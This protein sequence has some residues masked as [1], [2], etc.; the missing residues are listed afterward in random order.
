MRLLRAADRIS[1]QAGYP[2]RV[3]LRRLYAACRNRFDRAT[4]VA[5]G[6]TYRYFFHHYNKTWRSE[7]AIEIPLAR[8]FIRQNRGATR[9]LEV[10]NVL[11]HYYPDFQHDVVD[12]YEIA[13]GVMN[14][15]AA[16]FKPPQ[17]YGLVVSIST[18]E[19]VGWDEEPRDP[20]KAAR[21]YLN[22]VEN[23]LAPGGRLLFTV[24]LGHHPR[25]DESIRNGQ[26]PLTERHFL[27]RVARC[28]WV[29][30]DA[31][32]TVNARY[33]EPFPFANAVF[34]GVFERPLG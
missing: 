30:T 12:K 10:G 19:H 17:K 21:A 32:E 26:L 14:F 28:C 16:D 15:D 33:G 6:A 5:G 3:L 34:A 20:E 29:E 2:A 8:E 18:L 27:K 1:R 25:L 11:N 23:C 9:I 13:P 7:R 24:P 31:G 22:L 4:F